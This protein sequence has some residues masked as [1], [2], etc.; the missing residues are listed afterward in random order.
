[1]FSVLVGL[2]VLPEALVVPFGAQIGASTVQ[3][4]LLLATIPLGSAVGA[5]AIVRVPRSVRLRVAG[6]MAVLCGL[7]LLVSGLGP[8][9]WVAG[10]CWFTS[11]LL[12]AYQVEAISVLVD[13]IPA[14]VRGRLLGVVSSWLIG[15]QGAGFAVGG[16]LARYLTPGAAIAWGAAAGAVA[17]LVVVLG[18][19]RRLD[20]VPAATRLNGA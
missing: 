17:A 18:L 15:S 11:G 6:W 19:M 8:V 3:T 20:L 12:A 13:A 10:I 9:W 16:L 5:A 1:V 14:G 7:P 2:F 4:G